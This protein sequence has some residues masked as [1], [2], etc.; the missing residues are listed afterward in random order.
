M[1]CV[2]TK[3][4][5]E[6][7]KVSRREKAL[8]T[9]VCS[10]FIFSSREL[11]SRQVK[12][13]TC[14]A[15]STLSV[16]LRISRRFQVKL[17]L[18]HRAGTLGLSLE[19]Y[20]S[21]YKDTT[22]D[23]YHRKLRGPDWWDEADG[24]DP[25]FPHPDRL[26]TPLKPSTTEDT[27]CEA[28]NDACQ[29]DDDACQADEDACQAEDVQVGIDLVCDAVDDEI[30]SPLTQDQEQM[31]GIE[32]EMT[33]LDRDEISRFINTL[34]VGSDRK[35]RRLVIRYFMTQAH[36]WLQDNAQKLSEVREYY[37]TL[38]RRAGAR[39]SKRTRSKSK[40][41]HVE[42]ASEPISKAKRRRL[43]RLRASS[44]RKS[45]TS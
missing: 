19:D 13:T 3:D 24:P 22:H 33:R 34:G 32:K 6:E 30:E 8:E 10:P 16:L 39:R 42:A 31:L 43:S 25:E 44:R 28:D 14:E 5:V 36:F 7:L 45:F 4:L 2:S 18:L 23:R 17:E 21:S 20:I 41:R 35:K 37:N 12:V 38:V 40:T 11:R 29:A 27:A 15:G 26:D 9:V 1:D